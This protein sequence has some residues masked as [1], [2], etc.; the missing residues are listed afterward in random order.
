MRATLRPATR[1]AI[2][3]LWF[4]FFYAVMFSSLYV[5]A[6]H[7]PTPHHVPV[8]IVGGSPQVRQLAAQ[9]DA[10]TGPAF[11]VRV[12]ADDAAAR[13]AVLD[14]QLTA[15]YDPRPNPAR[16]YIATM[17]APSAASAAQQLFSSVAG[18]RPTSM[19]V[20]DLAPA[21]PGDPRGISIFY[22]VIAWTISGFLTAVMLNMGFGQLAAG[23][24]IGI[25]AGFA[26]LT[27]TASYLLAG[28][29]LGA[30]PA[31]PTQALELIGIGWLMTFIVAVV[32]I[33]RSSET[34]SRRSEPRLRRE[35]SARPAGT[36]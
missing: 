14:W 23:S 2:G 29:G 30:L 33:G 1:K 15:T 36:P 25:I 24:E 12:V 31:S 16:L 21:P 7:A 3:R 26:V 17:A 9:L 35:H 18:T 20:V 27:S 34:G 4:P 13:R 32:G 19:R 6:F 8:A 5:W 28:P 10:R 22:M 11:D